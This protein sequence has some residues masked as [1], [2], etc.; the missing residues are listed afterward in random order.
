M[1]FPPGFL[2]FG[3]AYGDTA[4]PKIDDGSTNEIPLGT[5]VVI[6]GSR[7]SGLYVS[8]ES[9]NYSY[10]EMVFISLMDCR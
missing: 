2:P 8:L 4:V 5:D 9:L 6:F 3:P 10:Y 7:R 1:F